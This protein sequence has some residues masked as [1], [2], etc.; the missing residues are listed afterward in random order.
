M[1]Y[2]FISGDRVQQFWDAY[3]A[4]ARPNIR[5]FAV[6]RFGDCADLAEETSDTSRHLEETGDDAP[7]I[8]HRDCVA[9]FRIALSGVRTGS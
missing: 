8:R 6:L 3:A 1:I 2:D 5:E 9:E 4:W 7:D